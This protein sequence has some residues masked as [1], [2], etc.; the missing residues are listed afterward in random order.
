M[1]SSQSNIDI[2]HT[3]AV[4]LLEIMESRASLYSREWKGKTSAHI[5]LLREL[6]GRLIEELECAPHADGDS[7][8]LNVRKI[9]QNG[10][11]KAIRLVKSSLEK[12]TKE[13]CELLRQ[14]ARKHLDALT[15]ASESMFGGN[16]WAAAAPFMPMETRSI[17]QPTY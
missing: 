17:P 11:D 8:A 12:E 14:Q 10:T 16:D 2:I 6:L 9:R 4:A 7:I 3:E 5:D 15:T 13:S 1:T